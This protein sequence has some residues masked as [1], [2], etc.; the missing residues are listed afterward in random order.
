VV[1]R[2]PLAASL[3][4][5]SRVRDVV[6]G[7][8]RMDASGRVADRAVPTALGWR[9]GDR[10]TLTAESGVVV[11]RRDP[12]GM[13]TLQ[14]RPYLVIPAAL[15]H[16]CGLRAGDQVLL[17]AWPGEDALAAYPLAVVDQAVRTHGLVP[18]DPGGTR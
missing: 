8:A 16:R 13:V 6:Y 15:R 10:L 2:L 12:G 17:A 1:R 5:R 4:G 3:P 14:A 11:A 7:L 18:A 9:G